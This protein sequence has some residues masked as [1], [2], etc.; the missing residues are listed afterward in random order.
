MAKLSLVTGGSLNGRHRKIAEIRH[1]T[2]AESV[3]NLHEALEVMGAGKDAI[4][5]ISLGFH[6]IEVVQA[7]A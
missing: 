3:S 7:D 5:H 2:G 1:E 6:Q 4:I